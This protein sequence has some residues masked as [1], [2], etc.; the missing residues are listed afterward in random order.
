MTANCTIYTPV[1]R[2]GR[3]LWIRIGTGTVNADGSINLLLDALPANGQL[4]V[5]RDERP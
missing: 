3:T 4:Q 5:R 1:R 2:A